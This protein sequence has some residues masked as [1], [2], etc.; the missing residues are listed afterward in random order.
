ME[1]CRSSAILAPYELSAAGT[2][3][4]LIRRHRPT[5]SS[6]RLPSQAGQPVSLSARHAARVKSLR[7]RRPRS[8]PRRSWPAS[9]PIPTSQR[10]RGASENAALRIGFVPEYTRIT[11]AAQIDGL[12]PPFVNQFRIRH[13]ELEAQRLTT[14]SLPL[15]RCTTLPN[16]AARARLVLHGKH[17]P[18]V[19]R[20]LL[21]QVDGCRISQRT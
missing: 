20:N 15:L 4:R 17:L 18:D 19:L 14:A 7:Q 11:R 9:M 6:F 16:R 2:C 3:R 5:C 8:S 1:F 12:K 21:Q 10:M 13:P